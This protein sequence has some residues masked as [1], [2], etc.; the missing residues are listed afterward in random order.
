MCKHQAFKTGKFDTHFVKNFYTP[1]KLQ[2]ET[3]EEAK[4]AAL[5]AFKL[6]AQDQKILRVP[7]L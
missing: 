3:Q 4:I 1:E 7:N 5:M 2:L 6:F